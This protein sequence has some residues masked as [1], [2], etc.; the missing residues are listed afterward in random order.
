MA[1]SRRS[2][3]SFANFWFSLGSSASPRLPPPEPFPLQQRARD[4]CPG[5]PSP[6]PVLHISA[7]SVGLPLLR[8]VW[9]VLSDSSMTLSFPWSLKPCNSPL[10]Q[11][12]SVV[13]GAGL[14]V[15]ISFWTCRSFEGCG[16]LGHLAT[17]QA[18]FCVASLV[19]LVDCMIWRR[20]IVWLWRVLDPGSCLDLPDPEGSPRVL[21]GID[22]HRP[23]PHVM[24]FLLFS[25]SDGISMPVSFLINGL[26]PC[27]LLV[28][29]IYFSVNYLFLPL[30]NFLVGF[31]ELLLQC[32]Y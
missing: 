3:A 30:S 11:R 15:G 6:S 29:C 26:C 28:I 16:H 25:W 21:P 17:L 24:F 12:L 8:V 27:C 20:S 5:L 19:L 7:G 13:V 31:W 4:Q 10:C 1:P 14:E 2:T 22:F 18:C 32:G 9:C 23:F